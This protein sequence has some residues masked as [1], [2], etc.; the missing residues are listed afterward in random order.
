MTTVSERNDRFEVGLSMREAP[1]GRQLKS[2]FSD[3][4][5]EPLPVNFLRALLAIHEQGSVDKPDSQ[6]NVGDS[7]ESERSDKQLV[8]SHSHAARVFQPPRA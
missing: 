6:S 8:L 3:V 7:C 1:I 4:L 5:N 2:H